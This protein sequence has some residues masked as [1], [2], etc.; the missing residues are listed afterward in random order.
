MQ[1]RPLADDR[2]IR[3]G[4]RP[5]GAARRDPRGH[6]GRPFSECLPRHWIP[7][8]TPGTA[9]GAGRR[10]G[11]RAG[12]RADV[13]TRQG[14]VPPAMIRLQ[15]PQWGP[16]CCTFRTGRFA[17]GRPCND[18][19]ARMKYLQTPGRERGE[20]DYSGIANDCPSAMLPMMEN[21]CGSTSSLMNRDE[22]S[23][24]PKC[25]PPG[26]SLPGDSEQS[27]FIPPGM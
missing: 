17:G 16:V 2:P 15:Q 3:L 27:L 22:P 21:R 12:P 24:N 4:R 23:A 25:A 14:T 11:P 13:S 8:G 18:D 19:D 5:L 1:C 10:A 6:F 20:I 9:T 26:W 7:I